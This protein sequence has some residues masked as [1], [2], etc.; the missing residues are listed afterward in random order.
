M[1]RIIDNFSFDSLAPYESIVDFSE[2][3]SH[4]FP[5]SSSHQSDI[6]SP[7]INAPTP[8]RL[9]EI[10][11]TFW[12]PSDALIQT[13]RRLHES[14]YAQFPCI[15][16]SYCSRLLYPYQIKWITRQTNHTFPFEQVYPHVP[17]AAHPHDNMKV[18]VCTSCKS[19]PSPCPILA[20][21]PTCIENVP[22]GK[23]KYLSPVYL[24]SSL[25]RSSNLSA[26][27]EYRSLKGQFGY[28][29]NLRTLSLYSGMLGAFLENIDQS[30]AENRWYHPSLREACEWLQQNNPYLKSY[31]S[32]ASRLLQNND[33]TANP[34]A[35]HVETEQLLPPVHRG[36]V[37][38]PP[39]DFPDEIHNEDSHHSRLAI[40]FL[41]TKED[42]KIPIALHDPELEALL[43]PD[44]FPDGH[45]H[46]GELQR[47]ALSTNDKTE[48]YGKYIKSKILGYD[49]RFR[50]H[51]TWPMWSY[52]QLEKYRNFQNN[53][54][55]VHQ[56]QIDS[57]QNHPTA[58]ELLI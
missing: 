7:S 25:G 2:P 37:V 24:H 18:A 19:T 16:C 17:L 20:E 13:L 34:S 30:S 41:C 11:H 32:L 9:Q 23:R 8:M 1:S 5:E 6:I 54:C 14:N 26:Y 45:G 50:Q 4:I 3:T 56:R 10:E 40:G 12:R 22:Y 27:S 15:P 48:T 21:I 49:P 58:A 47:N 52:L 53:M 57:E 55:I 44:L 38:V 42:N 28:S 51:P 29:K 46:Y 36:D 33:F 35:T 43:Y 31:H 39:Y